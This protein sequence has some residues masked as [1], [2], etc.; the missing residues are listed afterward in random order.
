MSANESPENGILLF[1]CL[2]DLQNLFILQASRLFP[3]S[4]SR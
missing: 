4:L 3:N 2:S 1:S